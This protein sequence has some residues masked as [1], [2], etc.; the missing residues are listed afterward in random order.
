MA[1]RAPDGANNVLDSN[2]SDQDQM[3]EVAKQLFYR[4]PGK[5][6]PYLVLKF[7]DKRISDKEH[8]VSK[9]VLTKFTVK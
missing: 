2:S 6:D 7:G 3:L 9:Q 8:Y 1:I 4:P 5:A